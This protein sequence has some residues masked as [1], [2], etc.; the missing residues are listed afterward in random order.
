MK[1]TL[2]RKLTVVTAAC[3]VSTLFIAQPALA[4]HGHALADA[5][6]NL[7][8]Q[9][10]PGVDG[11]QGPKGDDGNDGPQGPKGDDGLDGKDGKDGEDGIDGAVIGDLK[12]RRAQ[13]QEIGHR[14]DARVIDALVPL[15]LMFGYSTDLRSLTK[16]R[17]NF[18][19]EFHSF[20]NLSVQAP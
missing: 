3:L 5:M 11:P 9:G 6:I 16:G 20:D 19:L 1:E 2:F 14:G 12:K 10:P 8:L 13:I 18:T 7:S 15:R 17:A 4:E